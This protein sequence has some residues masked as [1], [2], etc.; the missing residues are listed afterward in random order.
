MLGRKPRV[1]GSSAGCIENRSEDRKSGSSL[2][3]AGWPHL[4]SIFKAAH[5]EL[6]PRTPHPL[7]LLSIFLLPA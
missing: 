5:T 1:A 4:E 2:E 6:K 3:D 7:S